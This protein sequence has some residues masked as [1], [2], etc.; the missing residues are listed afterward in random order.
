MTRW[1]LHVMKMKH[2]LATA[3]LV[4]AAAV[5]VQ[6]KYVE[7]RSVSSKVLENLLRL[8]P[9]RMFSPYKHMENLV[10]YDYYLH[11]NEPVTIIP[12]SYTVNTAING[13]R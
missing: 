4:C 5:T 10:T 13:T 11:K 1:R 12:M 6:A 9:K 2:I 7:K 8:Q 3:G